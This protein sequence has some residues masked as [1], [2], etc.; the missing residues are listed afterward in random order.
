LLFA[1][2]AALPLGA[3]AYMNLSPIEEVRWLAGCWEGRS[4]RAWTEEHWM[5]P[6]GGTMLGMSR[7]THGDSTVGYELMRISERGERL[8]FTA[9]PSAQP[10]TAFSSAA[11][12]ATEVV[13]T[14]PEHDFPQTIRYRRAGADSL[15]ARIEGT[16]GG[17][18]QAMDFPMARVACPD[19]RDH[20]P[21]P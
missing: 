1:S 9:H 13:F 19:G 12:S 8:V 18:L 15:V 3:L 2:L 5:E 16:S 11:I 17:Q 10:A 6:R 14:N 20:M 7:T 4:D 21:S